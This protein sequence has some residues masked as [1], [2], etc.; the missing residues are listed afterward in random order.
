M[1]TQT[2]TTAMSELPDLTGR[3]AVVTGVGQGVGE[4]VARILAEQGAAVAVDDFYADCSQ[5]V[6]ATITER[7]GSAYAATADISDQTAVASMIAEVEREL[8]QVD[9]LV[10]NGGNAAQSARRSRRPRTSGR[11]SPRIG[12]HGSPSTTRT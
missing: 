11:V 10:N 6:A 1:T 8:G 12:S 3:V 7:A 2:L 5:R 4:A 9:I